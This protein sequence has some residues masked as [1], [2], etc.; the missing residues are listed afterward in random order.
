MKIV[1]F[2]PDSFEKTNMVVLSL[3]GKA[4]WFVIIGNELMMQLQ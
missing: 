2:Y 3:W 4:D 1:Y